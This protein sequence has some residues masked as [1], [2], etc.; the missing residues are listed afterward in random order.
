MKKAISVILTVVMLL[1]SSTMAFA[2]SDKPQSHKYRTTTVSK[3]GKPEKA[4]TPTPSATPLPASTPKPAAKETP[5]VKEDN[6]GKDKNDA[7]LEKTKADILKKCDTMIEQLNKLRGYI[8]SSD[9]KYL[10]EFKDDETAKAA[11]KSIDDAITSIKDLKEVVEASTSSKELKDISKDLQD[12]W[13]KN[14]VIM[15]RITGLTTAARFKAAYDKTKELAD[16]LKTGIDSMKGDG[17]K[18]KLDALKA[19]YEKIQARLEA[20]RNKYLEAVNFYSS[21]TDIKNSDKNFK[22]AQTKLSEAQKE[23]NACLVD[24]KYLLEK[25]KVEAK[26]RVGRT[27]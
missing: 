5:Q 7:A 16:K 1:G 26:A 27:K 9:G 25:L 6:K 24:V 4:P 12:N 10:V 15:K 20:A 18:I 2:K 23:L 21:I 3:K 14:Q 11:V 17:V 22:T 19:D 8:V 13:L